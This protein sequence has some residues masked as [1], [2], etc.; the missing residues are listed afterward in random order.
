LTIAEID[1]LIATGETASN[2]SE[3][4]FAPL[5]QASRPA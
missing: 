4:M 3:N 5:R 2:V 1:N